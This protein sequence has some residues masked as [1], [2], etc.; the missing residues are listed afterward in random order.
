MLIFFFSLDGTKK[1]ITRLE[2]PIALNKHRAF[3]QNEAQSNNAAENHALFTLLNRRT[4]LRISHFPYPPVS[5][6]TQ[7]S[8][9]LWAKGALDPSKK[10]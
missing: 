5:N 9:R 1:T 6:R 10:D 4:M 2:R 7:H 3:F 8:E